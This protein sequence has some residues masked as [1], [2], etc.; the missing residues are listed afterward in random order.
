MV[1]SMEHEKQQ[2]AEAVAI[3]SYD[4]HRTNPTVPTLMK[5]RTLDELVEERESL[6]ETIDQQVS[7]DGFYEVPV[8]MDA[9]WLAT[10]LQTE[11]GSEVDAGEFNGVKAIVIVPHYKI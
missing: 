9:A 5:D 2:I 6:L 4:L 3:L 7:L 8:W 10:Q 11:F 1:H